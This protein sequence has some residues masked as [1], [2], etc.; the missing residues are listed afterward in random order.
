M[1]SPWTNLATNTGTPPAVD[2]N[3]HISG[4]TDVFVRHEC[5]MWLDGTAHIYSKPFD[6]PITGD[7]TVILNGT[8]NDITADAGSVD[9]YV[10]LLYTSPSPR[11]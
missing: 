6:F 1:A 4:G 9:V 7:F 5:L 2:D 10:C 8:A 11:D 3:V